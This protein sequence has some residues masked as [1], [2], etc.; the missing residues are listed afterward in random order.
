MNNQTFT[1]IYSQLDEVGKFI[2]FGRK[3]IVS[4][5]TNSLVEFENAFKPLEAQVVL[6]ECEIKN[7]EEK[8]ESQH[9]KIF[10][11]EENEKLLS[12]E[13]LTKHNSL[14]DLQN[15]HKV[16]T[17]KYELV[18]RIL[19][20]KNSDNKAME[21]FSSL[22]NNEF[23]IFANEE[24]SLQEEAKAILILQSIEKQ[25]Q[26][27]ISFSGT[28]NKNMIAVGGG[29]STGKSEFLNSFF[30]DKNVKLSIGIKPVTAIPTYI[31][32]GSS[33]TIKGYSYQGGAIDVSPD[34]YKQLSHDFVKSFDFN[35]K[36]IMPVMAIETPIEHFDKIC[37]IDTPGYN[38]SNTE[39]FTDQDFSTAQEYLKQ[40]NVLLWL[41]G[42]D[43]NG[44]IPSSDLDFIKKLS[45]EEKKL[46][47][48]ANK[49]DLRSEEDLEEILDDFEEILD[50]HDIDYEG[51][52]AYSSVHKKEIFNR[53]ISLFDFLT[54]ENNQVEVYKQISEE[55]YSVFDM[56]RNAIN[57]EIKWIKNIKSNFNSLE[58]ELLQLGY[59][60]NDNMVDNRLENMK[61]MFE[62]KK[63]ENQLKDLEKIKKMM[64]QSLQEVFESNSTIS[65][66][67]D[68]SSKNTIDD[69][70]CKEFSMIV[71]EV[72][73]ISG[74]G[75][76]VTG[77]VEYGII[78][79]G[80][81]IEIEDNKKKKRKITIL[82]IDMFRK[83]LEQAVAG[84][85]CGLVFKGVSKNS[86]EAVQRICK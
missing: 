56:Y 4:S 48:V 66:N 45:L 73:S 74:R 53:K 30:K 60:K 54:Q 51:I 20:A 49:A 55:L 19:S 32:A 7:L 58:L 44:T 15:T 31:M 11:L 33:N 21:K 62:V 2:K 65:I 61:R 23:M 75:T 80:D 14:E 34:L 17:T 72:F 69:H 5:I 68:N 42:L 71:E 64:V 85:T 1:A 76:I 16:L 22:L 47:V 79:V 26:L 82:E 40:S 86:L 63:L 28:S 46:Y 25:L 3:K 36:D 10:R 24:S 8:K 50:D 37:F 78:K 84:D 13:L 81:V 77:Y 43:S 57:D 70:P 38:P 18:S 9:N 83:T 39:A 41:I 52:S 6:L 59:E 29:F 12:N 67:G 35:L 27:M